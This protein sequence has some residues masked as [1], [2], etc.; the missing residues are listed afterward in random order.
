LSKDQNDIQFE[1]NETIEDTEMLLKKYLLKTI[2]ASQTSKKDMRIL[3]S[4]D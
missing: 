1:E 2:E 3:K 4:L